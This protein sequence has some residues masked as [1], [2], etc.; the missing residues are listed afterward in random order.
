MKF[1]AMFIFIA[2][3]LLLVY[4]PLAHMVWGLGGFIAG[5][6]AVDFAGG[7]VIHISSGSFW[8]DCLYHPW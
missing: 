5:L 2:F 1:S 8:F 6:G 4:Y 3:W 7:N